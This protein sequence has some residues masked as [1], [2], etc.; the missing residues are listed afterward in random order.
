MKSSNLVTDFL[1]IGLIAFFTFIF[2][3]IIT[4]STLEIGTW[5]FAENISSAIVIPLVTI[6]VYIIGIIFYQFSDWFI[7][8][9]LVKKIFRLQGIDNAENK[10]RDLAKHSYHEIL[11]RVIIDSKN[12]FDYLSY[13]RTIIR[14]TRS[15]ITSSIFIPIVHFL[16]SSYLFFKVDMKFSMTNL[17]LMI[18][19]SII[20]LFMR[21]VYLKV[22]KGYYHAIL[23]FNKIIEERND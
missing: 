22:G 7:D 13:R 16:Y 10:V 23:N 3:I 4:N 9:H 21:R 19:V 14:I 20:F 12:A 15:L 1:V 11:Q 17:I 8:R 5:S 18:L 2:P 6:G